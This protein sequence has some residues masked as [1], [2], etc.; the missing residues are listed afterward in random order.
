VFTILAFITACL[1]LLGLIAFTSE[2][3]TKEIGI[4]KAIGSSTFNLIVVLSSESLRL[5]IIS[6][7]IASAFAY[8]AIVLWL[9]NFAYQMNISWTVFVLVILLALAIALF[10]VIFVTVRAA[11]KNPVEALRFE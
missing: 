7:V 2:R 4:R 9:Q 10:T 5:I 3:R 11:S 8:Y 1:G 6:S